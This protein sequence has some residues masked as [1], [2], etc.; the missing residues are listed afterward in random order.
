MVNR[1]ECIATSQGFTLAIKRI[2]PAAFF[3]ASRRLTG[4]HEVPI[5]SSSQSWYSR[6]NAAVG[7]CGGGP[8]QSG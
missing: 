4:W 3:V 6:T 7:K 5:I 2:L 8:I 1:V